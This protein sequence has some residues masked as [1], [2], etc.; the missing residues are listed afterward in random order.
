MCLTAVPKG[1]I[2]N[3]SQLNKLMTSVDANLEVTSEAG[4]KIFMSKLMFM[5]DVYIFYIYEFTF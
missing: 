3:F 2:Q 1:T 4:N 5:D